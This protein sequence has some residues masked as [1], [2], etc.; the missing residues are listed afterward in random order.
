MLSKIIDTQTLPLLE[1]VAAF[2]ERRHEVLSGNLANLSTPDYR[3]RDLSVARFQQALG[4]AI[5]VQGA[6]G[7]ASP[8]PLPT[9]QLLEKH[10]PPELLT[11]VEASGP[12]ATFQDGNNRNVEHEVME[13][14]KNALLQSL[15]IELITTQ[16]SRLQSAISERA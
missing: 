2:T 1:K 10:F 6:L 12:G 8:Q 7:A 3:V 9:R 5:A 13:M 16:L 14:S 11:A 4:E 15:A